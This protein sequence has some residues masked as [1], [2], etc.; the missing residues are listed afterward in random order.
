VPQR[1]IDPAQHGDPVATARATVLPPHVR[2]FGYVPDFSRCMPG[3]LILSSSSAPGFIDRQIEH[4]QRL[5]GLADEHARWTHAAVFL[6]ED[7]VVEAVPNGGVVTRSLYQDIP[8]SILRVRRC[9]NLQNEDRYKI[10]LCAQ[11]MLGSRYDTTIAISAGLRVRF[12]AW[13]RYWFRVARPTIVCS[14]VFYD[15]H[16]EITRRLLADCPLDDLVTPAHLSA[17]NDLEDI[18]VPWLGVR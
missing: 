13:N 1:I 4:T 15:A 18:D 9:P 3:D 7:F 8:T 5:I 12:N 16:V 10:A 11:R 17:T 2:Q 14:K 6:Y